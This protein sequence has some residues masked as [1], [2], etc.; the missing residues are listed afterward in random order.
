M[1]CLILR[2]LIRVAMNVDDNFD[3][4]SNKYTRYENRSLARYTCL[5]TAGTAWNCASGF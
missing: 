3:C 4:M 2:R 5:H 1:F